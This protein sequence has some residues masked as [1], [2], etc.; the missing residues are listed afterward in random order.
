MY[1][2]TREPEAVIISGLSPPWVSQYWCHI[3]IIIDTSR[4]L[5]ENLS[6]TVRISHTWDTRTLLCLSSGLID[7]NNLIGPCLLQYKCW[8]Y[9]EIFWI[10]DVSPLWKYWVLE[11]HL[12]SIDIILTVAFSS[13]KQFYHPSR[14]W[15]MEDRGIWGWVIKTGSCLAS[16]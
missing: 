7:L 10:W 3:S 8:I 14:G 13:V 12:L 2:G 9:S 6:G 15:R 1:V 5:P 11:G 4:W 16:Q